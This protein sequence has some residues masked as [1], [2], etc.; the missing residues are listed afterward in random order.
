VDP[1]PVNLEGRWAAIETFVAHLSADSIL[2]LVRLAYKQRADQGTVEAFEQ[3]LKK[4]EAA[5]P[6]RD[7][8]RL[9]AMLAGAAAIHAVSRNDKIAVLAA[10]SIDAAARL[11][12]TSE[13]PDIRSEARAFLAAEGNRLRNNSSAP[14][15]TKP[16]QA[17]TKA[18]KDQIEAATDPLTLAKA[19]SEL[20]AK[21]Q[22]AITL[23]ST[24]LEA[25]SSWTGANLMRLE[26]ESD[27]MWWLLSGSSQSL[28]KD[29]ADTLPSVAALV[30]AWEL[31]RLVRVLPGPTLAE[32]LLIQLMRFGVAPGGATESSIEKAV[33]QLPTSMALPE[34]SDAVADLTPI[35][36]EAHHRS[37]STGIVQRTSTPLQ[38]GEQAYVET[39]L[40]RAN[41]EAR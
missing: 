6:I 22:A 14:S 13:V 18:L 15:A 36:A 1:N 33:A 11:G 31:G 30:G 26:E 27:M 10:Y 39:L 20:G 9:M 2:A 24:Q 3:E 12:W 28:G 25:A 4:S 23:L 32:R 38:L 41:A 8:E 29:W 17:L 5:F 7:N 34:L 40:V 35:L 21:A 19:V 16:P 37:S